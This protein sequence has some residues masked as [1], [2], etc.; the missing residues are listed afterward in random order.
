MIDPRALMSKDYKRP[1]G[2]PQAHEWFGD[3]QLLDLAKDR[4]A[5]G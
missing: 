1:S 5:C 4:I 3:A 2:K